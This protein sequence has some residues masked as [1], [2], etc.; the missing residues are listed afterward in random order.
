[1]LSLLCCARGQ[2]TADNSQRHPDVSSCEE[3]AESSGERFKTF[4]LIGLVAKG[5]TGCCHST[6]GD[7]ARLPPGCSGCEKEQ[8]IQIAA[9]AIN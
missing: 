6:G 7:A 3:R 4:I 5:G 2:P 9:L 1:M 8:E